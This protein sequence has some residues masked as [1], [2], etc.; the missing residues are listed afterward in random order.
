MNPEGSW[1]RVVVVRGIGLVTPLGLDAPSTW[2]ALQQ[3]R[4][5]IGAISLFDARGLGVRIA[6]QVALPSEAYRST[7]LDR[8]AR[9]R[10]ED[11]ALRAVDEA[12]SSA[13]LQPA[14][15]AAVPFGIFSGSEKAVSEDL[16]L[17][18]RYERAPKGMS[19]PELV[20]EHQLSIQRRSADSLAR[21]IADVLP[22]A[23]LYA[24]Y[25]QACAASAV[26]VAQ[27]VRWLRR[28]TIQRALVLGVDTPV[29]SASVIDFN[30][31]G[32]LSCRNDAPPEASRPFDARRDGFVLS[33]GAGALVLEATA[34][35]VAAR[36]AIRG[37][38]MNN[39]QDHI[40]KTP[41]SGARC[42][43]AMQAAL[44]DAGIDPEAID[45]VNAHGTST[46]VGDVGETNG[47]VRVFAS[48][49]PV[50]STKSMM[51]HLIA[52]AGIVE[53]GIACLARERGFLP[54]TINQQEADPECTLDYVANSGRRAEVTYAMSNSF[55]FGGTN[56][57]LVIGPAVHGG[58][59]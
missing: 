18:A 15:F 8:A 35:P 54:P 3:G 10:K 5:G 21:Q 24:N 16:S 22:P 50:S 9:D 27:A 11:L 38:G 26:A 58:P 20:R 33:E 4:S 57:A 37:V 2:A 34:A 41:L 43:A 44:E 19:E 30:L 6:G 25:A 49:P 23:R 59:V 48:P 1:S 36:T 53:L 40:T 56:V 46:D 45:Y 52:A 31:L 51:G 32:A 29:N 7:L 13:E 42:A 17:Y 39:N 47:I 12:I 14:D 55:G 28:G